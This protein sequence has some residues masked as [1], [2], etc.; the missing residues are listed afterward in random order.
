MMVVR[1]G[2]TLSLRPVWTHSGRRFEIDDT[3]RLIIV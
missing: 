2:L 3:G 1:D